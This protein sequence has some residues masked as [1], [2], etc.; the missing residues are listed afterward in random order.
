MGITYEDRQNNRNRI[1]STTVENLRE[2]KDDLKKALEEAPFA[3]VGPK[4]ALETCYIP[5]ENIEK[6]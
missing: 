1:L 5:Q 6:L 3:V 4:E 2:I